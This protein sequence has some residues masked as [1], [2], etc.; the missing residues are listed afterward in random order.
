M[1]E[2]NDYRDYWLVSY[3][4]I[5]GYVNEVFI[6]ESQEIIDFKKYLA[7]K[8]IQLAQENKR[9]ELQKAEE[10]KLFEAQRIEENRKIKAKQDEEN[11][12]LAAQKEKENQKNLIQKQI[13]EL[14]N[15]LNEL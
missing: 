6:N 7:A 1:I 5:T 10:K 3:G 2:F 14:Q 11:R 4:N 12:I 9:I 13:N 8:K 15:K